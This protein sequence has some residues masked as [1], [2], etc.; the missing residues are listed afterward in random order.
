MEKTS[1]LLSSTE[2]RR[3]EPVIIPRPR[4]W[5]NSG[6]KR[7]NVSLALLNRRKIIPRRQERRNSG[8]GWHAQRLFCLAQ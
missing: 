6:L 2:G 1:L 7:H 5:P 4:E 8:L 3:Q